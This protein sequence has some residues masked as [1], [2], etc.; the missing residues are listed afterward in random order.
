MLGQVANYCPVISRTTI[1]KSSTSLK[2]VWQAIRSHYGFQSSGAQILDLSLFKLE[3]NERHEDLFQR[4]TAFCEDNL[5]TG[6]SNIQHHGAAVDEDV[7]PFKI[8]SLSSG[9]NTFIPIIL[10]S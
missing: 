1:I 3:L 2:Y 7:S 9:Y 8:S 4:L 5:I 10:L 6:D